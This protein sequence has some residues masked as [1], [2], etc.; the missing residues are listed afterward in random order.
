MVQGTLR[1]LAHMLRTSWMPLLLLVGCAGFN[2]D[3][4]GDADEIC[5]RAAYLMHTHA[6]QYKKYVKKLKFE[7]NT[8]RNVGF[9]PGIK[10]IANFAAKKIA[11]QR[12]CGEKE[13]EHSKILN[14]FIDAGKL[15]HHAISAVT[16]GDGADILERVFSQLK[17]QV[18]TI[19]NT[20]EIRTALIDL[21]HQE[22][23]NALGLQGSKDWFCIEIER[24]NKKKHHV[25]HG[26]AFDIYLHQTAVALFA[27]YWFE[28]YVPK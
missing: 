15:K 22:M 7:M 12:G 17:K 28:T 14:R 10:Q 11:Q 3:I 5:T 26:D 24:R 13:L 2:G 16:H 19:R 25:I 20:V 4:Y 6:D 21:L 8:L 9:V 23:M 18:G 27:M 1:T